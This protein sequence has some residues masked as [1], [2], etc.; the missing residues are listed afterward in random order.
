MNYKDII[1][2]VKEKNFEKMY[3]FYG[4]EYYLIEN[5]IKA[6]KDSLN[7]GMLDFNLD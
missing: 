1:R 4:R 2:N 6:F 7:E 3:L 5:A